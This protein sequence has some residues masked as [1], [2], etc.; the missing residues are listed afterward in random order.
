MKKLSQTVEKVQRGKGREIMELWNWWFPLVRA[1]NA[2]NADQHA[3]NADNADNADTADW[4]ADEIF[5]YFLTTV[6]VTFVQESFPLVTARTRG[7]KIFVG[8]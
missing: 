2:D 4:H 1:D 8:W 3:D 7:R 5:E 6:L